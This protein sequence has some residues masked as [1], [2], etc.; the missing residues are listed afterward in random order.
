[1]AEGLENIETSVI[2]PPSKSAKLYDTMIEVG[3]VPEQLG[4]DRE[5][6]VENM[7]DWNKAAG[8]YDILKDV[9]FQ[10]NQLGGSK[11]AFMTSVTGRK[12]KATVK[13]GD[14]QGGAQ[15]VTPM[16]TEFNQGFLNYKKDLDHNEAA[17][18]PTN[19]GNVP[20][21]PSVRVGNDEK[22][23]DLTEKYGE[24]ADVYRGLAEDT[25]DMPVTENTDYE[26]LAELKEKNPG[27]YRRQV[28]ANTWQG[29]LAQNISKNESP[30]AAAAII[31]RLNN[32]NKETEESYEQSKLNS[33][34]M[35][36][37]VHK[38]VNDTQLQNKII[39]ALAVDR[40]KTYADQLI[41]GNDEEVAG[42]PL[43]GKIN[44]RQMIALD[45][46]KTFYPAQA[47]RME[48]YVTQTKDDMPTFDGKVGWDM[49]A[50]ELEDI[51]L[52]MEQGAVSES[53]DRVFRK[54]MDD[55]TDQDKAVAEHLLQRQGDIDAQIR[56]QKNRYPGWYKY[57]IDRLVQ[58]AVGSRYNNAQQFGIMAGRTTENL[59]RLPEDIL[60][61]LFGSDKD[62]A[63]MEL[64]NLGMDEWLDTALMHPESETPY[65]TTRTDY[66]TTTPDL[67]D[68]KKGDLGYDEKF[69]AARKLISQNYGDVSVK[70]IDPKMNLTGKVFLNSVTDVM[71]QVLPMMAVA[72]LT[73]GSGVGANMSRGTEMASLFKG[74]FLTM[75]EQMKSA[76]IREGVA[77]PETRAMIDT[78]IEALS[79]MFPGDF[80]IIK[81]MAG[82]TTGA[83]GQ[84]LK[85]V[86]KAEWDAAVKGAGKR[87]LSKVM[88]TLGKGIVKNEVEAGKEALSEYASGKLQALTDEHV[89]GEA[90]DPTAGNPDFLTTFIGWQPMA[91]LGLA[92]KGANV[93]MDV[94][95][96]IQQYGADPEKAKGYYEK[97]YNDGEISAEERNQWIEVIDKASQAVSATPTVKVN[98]RPYSDRQKAV[99]AYN[100]YLK[101]DAADDLASDSPAIKTQAQEAVKTANDENELIHTGEDD[102]KILATAKGETAEEAETDPQVQLDELTQYKQEIEEE[103]VANPTDIQLKKDL[104]DV[105]RQIADLEAQVAN[106]PTGAK[107]EPEPAEVKTEPEATEVKPES[108]PAEVKAEPEPA[109]VAK[110]SSLVEGMENRTVT[111]QVGDR[112]VT[113]TLYTTPEGEHVVETPGGDEYIV[114]KNGRLDYEV[115]AAPREQPRLIDDMG[116]VRI[117]DDQYTSPVINEHGDGTR[118]VTLKD[119]TG[120]EKVV[121]GNTAEQIAYEVRLKELDEMPD[122]EADALLAEATTNEDIKNLIDQHNEKRNQKAKRKRATKKTAEGSPAEI[123]AEPQREPEPLT[124]EE[125]EEYDR[126]IAAEE[127]KKVVEEIIMEQLKEEDSGAVKVISRDGKPKAY[128][129]TRKK[130]GKYSVT[131]NGRAVGNKRTREKA[132]AN[133]KAGESRRDMS[134]IAELNR[135]LQDEYDRI[136]REYGLK[137]PQDEVEEVLERERPATAALMMRE[138]D[139]NGAEFTN[140]RDNILAYFASGGKM[141]ITDAVRKLFGGQDPRLHMNAGK[142]VEAER[143]SRIGLHSA[144]GRG[145][146]ALA[147]WLYEN[148]PV[149]DQS[150]DMDYRNALEDVLLGHNTYKSMAEE[151]YDRHHTDMAEAEQEYYRSLGLEDSV[152]E[153]T[154]TLS[155]AEFTTF[156]DIVEKYRKDDGSVDWVKLEND[157]SGFDPDILN[158]P[159]EASNKLEDEIRKNTGKPTQEAKESEEE[160]GSTGTDGADSQ[161][162]SEEESV[163]DELPFESEIEPHE[164]VGETSPKFKG[165]VDSIK[166]LFS[167]I[168][169]FRV[170]VLTG[171]AW[172]AALKEA[173]GGNVS[174]FKNS[175][176]IYGYQGKNGIVLNGAKLNL[177]TPIHEAAHVFL[178][179][180]KTEA[181]ELRAA[182][183]KLFADKNNPYN[184]AVRKDPFYQAQMKGMSVAK[185]DAFVAEE[186]LARAVGDR[187]EKMVQD[188]SKFKT[189]L[190]DFWNKVKNVLGIPKFEKFTSAQY[191]GQK[192]GNFA[193]AMA[194]RIVEGAPLKVTTERSKA[195]TVKFAASN[196]QPNIS[197]FFSEEK[198]KQIEDAF[199]RI[200]DISESQAGVELGKMAN[201]RKKAEAKEGFVSKT[202]NW[203]RNLSTHIDNPYRYVTQL[204]RAIE[205]YYDMPHSKMPLGRV[206]EQDVKGPAELEVSEFLETVL[207]GLRGKSKLASKMP[208]GAQKLK[209]LA[210][211]F[212]AYVLALRTADRLAQE[213]MDKEADPDAGSRATGALTLTTAK[214]TIEAVR[215]AGLEADFVER[216]KLMQG[217]ANRILIRLRQSGIIS[218]ETY[219]DIRN[220]ND[221]Y[222]PFAV[223]QSVQ[224][225]A[226]T[227]AKSLTSANIIKKIKG[228]DPKIK[229]TSNIALNRLKDWFDNGQITQDEY[230]KLAVDSL[231]SQF[232]AGQLSQQDYNDQMQA[233]SEVG[234]SIGNVFDRF[235][236][237]IYDS[238]R[239]AARNSNLLKLA[240]FVDLATDASD[241]FGYTVA[242][243]PIVSNIKVP[244]G[245]D[246][247]PYKVLGKQRFLVVNENAAKVLKGMDRIELNLLMKIANWFN[248]IFRAGVITLSLGF[249]TKNMA[250]DMVRNATV[251]KYGI[252]AGRNAA[253]RAANAILFVPQYVEALLI[254]LYEHIGRPVARSFGVDAKRTSMYKAFMQSGG[255]SAGLFDDLFIEKKEKLKATDPSSW[256]R[257]KTS[258][259]GVIGIM[260]KLGRVMEES[261]KIVAMERGMDAEGIKSM[262]LTS[263]K[264]ALGKA[265]GPKDITAAL[266]AVA[267]EMQNMAGSPNF[268]AASTGMKAL[269]LLFQFFSARVKGQVSDLRRLGNMLGLT[270]DGVRLSAADR[271]TLLAQFSAMAIPIVLNAIAN[272]ADDDDEKEMKQN[273][274]EFDRNKNIMVRLGTF[275][276]EDG[277]EHPDYLKLGVRDIPALINHAANG[278]VEFVKHEDPEALQLMVKKIGGEI[279]PVDLEFEE[280]KG[281]TY[282]SYLKQYEENAVGETYTTESLFSA[283]TPLMKLLY[284]RANDRN[285]RYHKDLIPGKVNREYLK[286]DIPPEAVVKTNKKGEVITPEW[287]IE[288]A[289]WVNKTTGT[290]FRPIM[291]D[292]LENTLFGNVIDNTRRIE[293]GKFLK[294]SYIRSESKYPVWEQPEKQN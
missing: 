75:Y 243:N 25:R 237:M 120:Q 266:D 88:A 59:L 23:I 32:F 202:W 73:G 49:K 208:A 224:R 281:R 135:Q 47:A 138:L 279:T 225:V 239:I 161:V 245:F 84:I 33:Q 12:L 174:I 156:E 48:N 274:T 51:G 210:D 260:H 123:D 290:N 291:I 39:D 216:A 169:G 136:D 262:G 177:N 293:G 111:T 160:T 61:K 294:E 258:A 1:M 180:A 167:K 31:T 104:D 288:V 60:V 249:Q 131:Y 77:N 193:E 132:I 87:S 52:R 117:G 215:D 189:W 10:D 4:G 213:A 67:Q 175:K 217:F 201:V 152:D 242:K 185:A 248:K 134:T 58:N 247:V 289:K 79:E 20:G 286:G 164:T 5:T 144:S 254:G 64:R 9:G 21:A 163:D 147:H 55:W 176:G 250:I 65:Q 196:T 231:E 99:I 35:V 284:E 200:G 24:K 13:V 191:M 227:N 139:D 141:N 292:H 241:M 76:R 66:G 178:E 259:S 220:K 285:S 246:S 198:Q 127:E 240:G 78:T 146:D 3:F 148:R 119:E 121:G 27:L 126:M 272:Y 207:H 230:Y 46:M 124:P 28:A 57:E 153:V 166:K 251:S 36:D 2:D 53:L 257:I 172:D 204:H 171:R 50:K 145:L 150:T 151:L 203:F 122:A 265:N 256:Q 94:K 162:Q 16:D 85:K 154:D 287:A 110:K 218:T 226:D 70:A 184:K 199:Q 159:E 19:Y 140:A 115:K 101:L 233:L 142:R 221:F 277:V 234:F 40:Q 192:W 275:K 268:A 97:L 276:D 72:Y 125:Q 270:G 81:K 206:M 106:K 255:Y 219:R 282:D 244:E 63:V 38:Y 280:H 212:H 41:F 157:F 83:L 22:K 74:T 197:P 149:G 269:S 155:D 114:G 118:T 56:T 187:G 116:V 130:D 29:L 18:V 90:A 183:L 82:S 107:P 43:A 92:K 54:P 109:P 170:D 62:K 223:V 228:I 129:V 95:H 34:E 68:I 181:L 86:T 113:G 15:D 11:G 263:W 252:F 44:R 42:N 238:Y 211:D 26:K 30:E 267:F 45:W 232:T 273:I 108:E 143:R 102:E 182:G 98:G 168:P 128:V 195:P 6:F 80:T 165:I 71:G 186:A 14:L 91:F 96:Q 188:R 69:A 261:H 235:A 278:V 222:A 190:K 133:W 209:S 283:T 229:D 253:D 93:G 264:K 103:M 179:W 7:K 137:P 105:N 214:A 194:A 17:G 158:L 173:T 112:K 8:V 236:N 100:N 205:S 89:F 271:G 37:T